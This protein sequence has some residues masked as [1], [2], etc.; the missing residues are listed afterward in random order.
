MKPKN[1]HVINE[2]GIEELIEEFDLKKVLTTMIGTEYVGPVQLDNQIPIGNPN[3]NRQA[4]LE[5]AHCI[6][7]CV[8]LPSLTIFFNIFSFLMPLVKSKMKI[9][10]K[11]KN[12]L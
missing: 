4:F 5:I 9:C 8:M 1:V 2:Q 10:L 6:L 12:T 3:I 11:W 7:G